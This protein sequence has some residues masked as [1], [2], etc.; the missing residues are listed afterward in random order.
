VP[1]LLLKPRIIKDEYAI[2]FA[3]QR[4]HAGN[5]LP[6]KRV[7]IPDHV[8]Q[9]VVELLLVG[10]G[11][12]LGQGVAVFVGLIP[13]LLT[14]AV[15]GLATLASRAL[16][17]RLERKTSMSEARF[18][19]T[20]WTYSIAGA[21][22]AAG[23]ADFA[24]VAY[25]LGQARIASP[26]EISAWYA[27]AMVATAITAPILGHVLDGIG[28]IAIAIGI[29]VS[30][31]AVPLAFLGHGWML[32]LGVGMWGVG[33][34][35][36]D[37]L[38]VALVADITPEN[39]RSTAYGVFDTIYGVAWAAGSAALGFLYDHFVWGL[40]AL[41]MLAQLAAIA[42]FFVGYRKGRDGDVGLSG[43]SQ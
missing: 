37:S 38:F 40:V 18:S 42:V 39:I 21:L 25:H 31:A 27:I 16:A 26:A 14:L 29:A 28:L 8:G 13:A 4:L 2:A 5:P 7:L 24:L 9:Q 43:L 19:R 3:R 10:L 12:H 15:L 20:F 34:T 36:Q 33:T 17:E 41:S 11:H 35:V 32:P 23:Y 6:V 1:P 22:F 30:A